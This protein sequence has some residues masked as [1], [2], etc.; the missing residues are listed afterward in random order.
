MDQASPFSIGGIIALAIF[1]ASFIAMSI[2]RS[3]LIKVVEELKRARSLIANLSEQ[4]EDLE[5]KS[6]PFEEPRLNNGI[7]IV[8]AERYKLFINL[9]DTIIKVKGNFSDTL[10]IVSIEQCEVRITVDGYHE[11]EYIFFRVN[12]SGLM[13]LVAKGKVA[14]F[15]HNFDEVREW[16]IP[17][18]D[19]EWEQALENMKNKY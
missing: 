9:I 15:F 18:K 16:F 2:Y 7:D 11:D 6:R 8:E 19:E 4:V 1:F 14:Q 17:K 10:E 12:E 3:K 5:L 13:E